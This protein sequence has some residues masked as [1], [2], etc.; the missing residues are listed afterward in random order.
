M[1]Y[2]CD[3]IAI[4]CR[5]LGRC[6]F[7]AID[8]FDQF[9]LIDCSSRSSWMTVWIGLL[10]S[11]ISI[12]RLHQFDRLLWSII[13]IDWCDRF[14]LDRLTYSVI[15]IHLL[16][17]IDLIDSF[18]RLFWSIDLID[19]ICFCDRLTRHNSVTRRSYRELYIWACCLLWGE[20][21][22]WCFDV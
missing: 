22:F 7:A 18:D 20:S 16:W 17:L 11:T 10:Q 5:L 9:P 3:I 2:Q 15:A 4:K 8:L 14:F 19:S 1:V 12:V 6:D 21:M 13:S